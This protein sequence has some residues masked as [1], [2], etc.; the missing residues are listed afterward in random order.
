MI[1]LYDEDQVV[2]FPSCF[3]NNWKNIISSQSFIE[4]AK[5]HN[6]GGSGF[7]YVQSIDNE[8]KRVE[9]HGAH[10]YYSDLKKA[11]R[12]SK[13]QE[14][15]NVFVVFD[16]VINDKAGIVGQP[17]EKNMPMI[18][19]LSGKKF[20]FGESK[21]AVEESGA[22]VSRPF[23]E[24]DV[25]YQKK[26]TKFYLPI[27]NVEESWKIFKDL[28]KHDYISFSGMKVERR[29]KDK[30]N[31]IEDYVYF[32]T[33]YAVFNDSF[34]DV[35]KSIPAIK[36]FAE[37]S[38][39]LNVSSKQMMYSEEISKI[40]L[41]DV[42][43]AKEEE[44]VFNLI[45]YGEGGSGKCLKEGTPVLLG[46]GTTRKI[47]DIDVGDRVIAYNNNIAVSTAVIKKF[48][49][50]IK[51]GYKLKLV[52]G[53]S[54][55][56]S[57]DHHFLVVSN[58]NKNR[59]IVNNEHKDGFIFEESKQQVNINGKSFE[60]NTPRKVYDIS[61]IE[62]RKLK[63]IKKGD[64]I[65]EPLYYNRETNDIL[66]KKLYELIG[67]L[68]GDGGLTGDSVTITCGRDSEVKRIALLLPSGMGIYK[69][70]GK[71]SY[72]I[73]CKKPL[74]VPTKGKRYR[75]INPIRQILSHFGI[76]GCGSGSKFIPAELLCA[77]DKNLYALL[78]GL[79]VTDGWVD[80][81]KGEVGYGTVSSR[82][83]DDVCT[84]LANLGIQYSLSRRR[85]GFYRL[86]NGEKKIGQK[87]YTISINRFAGLKKIYDNCNLLFKHSKLGCIIEK[88]I[89]YPTLMGI[90]K[91][92][93][94]EGMQFGW[95]KSIEDVGEYQMYD[96]ETEAHN[97]VANGI[98]VHNSSACKIHGLIFANDNNFIDMTISTVSGLV[99]SYG[100]GAKP[101]MLLL[102]INYTKVVDEL[103]RRS[104]GDAAMRG[105]VDP[106]NEITHILERLMGV[107]LRSSKSQGGSGKGALEKGMYMKDSFLASDNMVAEVRNAFASKIKDGAIF[108]RFCFLR[109]NDEDKIS[110][111]EAD[112]RP[113]SNDLVDAVDDKYRSMGLDIGTVKRFSRWFRKAV[114][115]V[116]LSGKKTKAEC[117]SIQEEHL[118]DIWNEMVAGQ[119]KLEGD[120]GNEKFK[121]FFKKWSSIQNL[122]PTYEGFV[123]CCAAARCVEQ[124]NEEKL[125][126]IVVED[127]DYIS[128]SKLFKRVFI[129]TC[130]IYRTGITD[131]MSDRK[132]ETTY[133]GGFKDV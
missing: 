88:K 35:A 48:N 27:T 11:L 1:R 82:L 41:Y 105:K 106:S 123:R 87:S 54:I 59:N 61:G 127:I 14:L 19:E 74:S 100:D 90:N 34:S 10:M 72:T 49:T 107:L 39:F 112:I 103:F 92:Y 22:G 125:P 128:A 80:E 40:M 118:K 133:K 63:D 104:T 21:N 119:R 122:I 101:G 67:Y 113:S 6:D 84:L 25:M 76:M 129:D 78:S 60:R 53:K 3:I 71:Y 62:W 58:I 23:I 50:G 130:N 2:E 108:R 83:K 99:P 55:V 110:V 31:I 91:K 93:E 131:W 69:T 68:L 44:P 132:I 43:Y 42:F 114:V 126:E 94:L 120:E 64:L 36:N 65:A 109:I 8:K 18:V 15:D 56:T 51:K 73:K 16:S 66:D 28:S 70:S 117:E 77:S 102:P 38:P 86:T 13:Q 85:G 24:L 33:E 5:K 32:I 79:L 9:M 75:S 26:P 52:G 57:E 20:Y 47:E 37:L 116:K 30:H 124:C 4:K 81:K 45:V 17:S 97:Y 98:I 46:N 89:L 96:I 121:E 12:E 111:Q 7:V 115:N 95:V 29:I